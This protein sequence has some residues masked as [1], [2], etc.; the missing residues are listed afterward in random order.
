MSDI[1]NT[2]D[3][4]LVKLFFC[5]LPKSTAFSSQAICGRIFLY[6]RV[7]PGPSVEYLPSE[8]RDFTKAGIVL[9]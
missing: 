6:Y 3:S 8:G 9:I 5:L 2:W 1:Q 7:E 4:G